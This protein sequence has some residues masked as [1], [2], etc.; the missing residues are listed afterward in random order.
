MH[1]RHGFVALVAL[2]LTAGACSLPKA[3][4]RAQAVE[5]SSVVRPG[6]QGEHVARLQRDLRV[7]GIDVDI[8][9]EFDT[10]MERDVESLQQFFD[11]G[12]DGIVGPRTRNLLDGL[13]AKT[14]TTRI[15]IVPPG[16]TVSEGDDESAATDATAVPTS[17]VDV[18][19]HDGDDGWC[20][21]LLAGTRGA[22]R[23]VTHDASPLAVRYASVEGW[24]DLV[25]I[26]LVRAPAV[27]VTVI[28]ADG[29]EQDLPVTTLFSED[30]P[31]VGAFAVAQ[32]ASR[33][34]VVRAVD[35]SGAEV[36]RQPLVVDED[37]DLALGDVG[38]AV[39]A[40]QRRFATSGADVTVDG[41]FSFDLAAVVS[42]AQSYLQLESTGRIDAATRGALAPSLDEPSA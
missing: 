32:P 16:T 29:T 4:E 17:G 26:G 30:H 34:V 7:L 36:A 15:E 6:D 23:C 42:A 11:L 12:V 40:W 1:V 22:S 9:G 35:A 13:L 38:P 3:E 25:L 39:V 37:A 28:D 19:V 18:T 27:A 14:P 21:E 2:A 31:G 5:V 20:F 24:D 10:A 33:A 41:V 8:D